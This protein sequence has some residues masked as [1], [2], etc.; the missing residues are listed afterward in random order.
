MKALVLAAGMGTRLRPLTDSRPKPMLP[1]G[2]R[3]L[4]E[5]ILCWLRRQGV[6]EIAVNLHYLPETITRHF[7][8]GRQLGVRLTYSYEDPILGSAGAAR[9]LR[10]FLVDTFLVVYGDLLLDVDLHPFL[11]FHRQTG[12]AVSIGLKRTENPSANGMV[13]VD[14]SGRVAGFIEKPLDGT[15][16]GSL[17]NAGV[18]VVEPGVFEWIPPGR[19]YDF[20]QHLFPALLQAGVPLHATVL[21]GYLLDIGNPEAYRQAQADLAAGLVSPAR[22]GG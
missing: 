9:R 12:G 6:E 10:S 22:P 3:P 13:E 1:V 14:A 21:R 17:A 15:Y 7:Q 18:Y 4:L 5:H 11:F 2:G 20:G 8:D 19:F 16:D